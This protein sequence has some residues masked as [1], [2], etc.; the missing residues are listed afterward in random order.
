MQRI[1]EIL[2]TDPQGDLVPQLVVNKQCAEQALL[3]FGVVWE[4]PRRRVLAQRRN[5]SRHHGDRVH[6]RERCALK[7]LRGLAVHEFENPGE[8]ASTSAV[9]PLSR[10]Q[11][12]PLAIVLCAPKRA[13]NDQVPLWDGQI[14]HSPQR[15]LVNHLQV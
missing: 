1:A 15:A 12:D 3:G 8:L 2:Y 4:L 14:D 11:S 5:Q 6:G 9:G 13:T 10:W 7:P